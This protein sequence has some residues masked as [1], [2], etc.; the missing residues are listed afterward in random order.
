MLAKALTTRQ[1][2]R[3]ALVVTAGFAASGVLG[4]A[5]T[6]IFSV[7]FGAGD[8]L[9][10]FY[11]A[12]RVPELL[13]VLVAGGALGSSFIPVFS[14]LLN[15]GDPAGAWRLAS[16]VMTCAG[17]AAA[18][19]AL[20]AGLLAPW[21]VPTLLV[22]GA[23]T[24]MKILTTQLT[25][26]MLVTVVIFSISGL[27]MGILNTQGVFSLP[28]LAA[29]AKN[30]GEIIGALLI[31]PLMPTWGMSAAHL[32]YS[33]IWSIAERA[34]PAQTGIFGLAYG[35]ILGAALHFLVQMP[36]LIRL[37]RQFPAARL[38]WLPD[39]RVEGVGEVLRLML[40][41]VFGLAITQINFLVNVV[42]TSGM[43]AGSRTALTT[44]WTLMFFAL[45]IIGQSVGTALFPTL[46]AL[47]ASNDFA[48]FRQRLGGALR[49]VALLASLATI[50]M[51]AF[52]EW[53]I[54]LL[55]ERI[56]GGGAWTPDDT[57][58]TAWALTFFAVG[59]VGHALLEVLS[60]G[61]YALSDTRTPVLIGA[62]S[63][64][65]NI[66]LSLFFIR[67]IGDPASLA[68]G[69]FAGLALA[70]S[71]TTLVEAGVLWLLMRRRLMRILLLSQV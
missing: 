25:Q 13:F 14:R 60:R 47:A 55:F 41:R 49:G 66:L 24:A 8:A 1:I 56:F 5:R 31:V 50:S 35:A 51:I 68:R 63:M 38:R 48:G 19:L 42:L 27:L 22:P 53:G 20:T 69:T 10:A 26:T 4:L 44:A 7:T 43:I 12:Q 16:A 52:G 61:F 28:A 36:G 15:R 3:A 67:L 30:I 11:A 62:G 57:R 45:G 29:S 70:N 23:S 2:I 54:G 59:I 58:A 9:D 39:P 21:F 64:I 37:R 40:P 17:L 65:A 33:P 46:A 6:S 18:L 71:I 34:F 32:G